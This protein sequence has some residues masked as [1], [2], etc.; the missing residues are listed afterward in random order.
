MGIALITGSAGLIGSQAARYFSDK[1]LDVVG[2]DNNM[3][4]YFF[5]QDGST[6]WNKK[7]LQKEIK[8]YIHKDVDIRDICSLEKL[9]KKYKDEIKLVIHTAAQP[10]HDWAARE[11]LTDFGINANGTLNLL[12]QGN[13]AVITRIALSRVS[14]TC[15]AAPK[16]VDSIHRDGK[17]HFRIPS[18]LHE[19]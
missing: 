4:A 10:S 14:A 19:K 16:P 1:G 5:G 2:I 7:A 3:R 18:R 6:E 13:D 9:F 15:N 11:P 17:N 8:G 12:E